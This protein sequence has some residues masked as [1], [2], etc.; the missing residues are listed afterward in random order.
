MIVEVISGYELRCTDGAN[1]QVFQLKERRKRDENKKLSDTVE[2]EW[3]GL[4]SYH[5]SV[6]SGVMWILG[7]VPKNA[8]NRD[9]RKNLDEFLESMKKIKSSISRT[10]K[11][12]EL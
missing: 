3:V 7:H 12:K 11:K 6:E 4:Q 8:K 2:E 1:W 5:A 10:I 9:E